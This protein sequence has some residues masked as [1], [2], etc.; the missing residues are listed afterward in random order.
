MDADVS[1]KA[2]VAATTD[3]GTDRGWRLALEQ[4]LNLKIPTIYDVFEHDGKEER[5][6]NQEATL[7][8]REKQKAIKER[9]R[10][11][12]SPI[13]SAP[14]AWSG[15]I[16]TPTT[17]CVWWC[18]DGAHPG[19]SGDEPGRLRSA[20][21]EGRG[22]ALMSSGNTLLAHAVGAGK[23]FDMAAAGM[24]MKQAGLIKKPLYVVPN[25]MLEHSSCNSIRTPACSIAGQGGLYP[26]AP[27]APH[28]QDRQRRMGRHHRHP[29]LV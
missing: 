22:V 9:F 28:R 14:N 11:G 3:Y 19:F 10:P 23:T 25:H 24:K 2:S 1:V 20:A 26:R 6:L 17:T 29:Q 8:A 5:V 15:S 16:T 4:A 18:F 13:P 21:S 12:S 27:Q 7:A